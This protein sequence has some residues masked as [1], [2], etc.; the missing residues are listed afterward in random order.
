MLE[1]MPSHY[2]GSVG[3]ASTASTTASFSYTPSPPSTAHSSTSSYP[4]P[5]TT[6]HHF[7]SRPTSSH[8][9]S[10]P[11]TASPP[12]DLR[13]ASP[14][15]L[16]YL[17][18]LGEEGGGGGTEEE[19]VRAVQRRRRDE[20]TKRQKMLD[21][22]TVV[23]V[24]KI[25]EDR[26]KQLLAQ[27]AASSASGSG[28]AADRAE[29]ER[30]GREKRAEGLMRQLMRREDEKRTAVK[31][32]RLK[33]QQSHHSHQHSGS[34]L[35][36]YRAD[37]LT[38]RLEG[39][40]GE[41][42]VDDVE[43]DEA[44]TEESKEQLIRTAEDDTFITATNDL[45]SASAG[46]AIPLSATVVSDTASSHR[47]STH[48]P[49]TPKA[50]T[51][52]TSKATRS[53][54]SDDGSGL[55]AYTTF[56]QQRV[57]HMLVSNSIFIPVGDEGLLLVNT[58]H[59]ASLATQY[60]L[61]ATRPPSPAPPQFHLPSLQPPTAHFLPSSASIQLASSD[62][63]QLYELMLFLARVPLLQGCGMDVFFRLSAEVREARFDEYEVIA[64]EGEEVEWVY[65]VREGRIDTK[66]SLE[67]NGLMASS[68]S[69]T[70][71]TS[72]HGSG[73]ALKPPTPTSPPQSSGSSSNNSLRRR[74]YSVNTASL[75]VSCLGTFDLCGESVLLPSRRHLTSLISMTPSACYS[76]SASSLLAC[77]PPHTLTSLS[78]YSA[79]TSSLVSLYT[80][81]RSRYRSS[82]HTS[83]VDFRLFVE[84]SLRR[85]LR[86]ANER[87]RMRKEIERLGG[88]G[89]WMRDRQAS[90]QIRH[91]Q[92]GQ[93]RVTGGGGS[94]GGW[95][96]GERAA[97][98]RGGRADDEEK[99]QLVGEVAIGATNHSTNNGSGIGGIR[100]SVTLPPVFLSFTT[101][102]FGDTP[103]YSTE[104]SPMS[105]V[106]SRQQVLP[107]VLDSHRNIHPAL[108]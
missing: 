65:L 86:H 62:E 108:R 2:S 83:V 5:S 30:L 15:G 91:M 96:R 75:D 90:R 104:S 99:E 100:R 34:P 64:N 51:A 52:T 7:Y 70:A 67:R 13:A 43:V 16:P 84:G 19:R 77:L 71:A 97:A 59:N 47:S 74:F 72:T 66:L 50:A 58:G 11:T 95:R 33:Q 28:G 80:A 1:R 40:E 89:G 73:G 61:A 36:S 32:D 38:S 14:L 101:L 87:S 85:N 3:P 53:T 82:Y 10:P 78:L 103:V 21:R 57:R 8:T 27:Q 94:G 44:G 18:P 56:L 20:Q 81:L 41:E 22:R 17:Q 26:E 54:A 31:L 79:Y 105:S 46:P 98:G 6:G 4:S 92:L 35:T 106:Q 60:A 45:Q 93:R 42:W 49:S 23:D 107:P 29:E 12:D 88:D 76:L 37:L 9:S 48:T 63:R 102:N 69:A 39:E 25:R 24:R 68:T 55:S